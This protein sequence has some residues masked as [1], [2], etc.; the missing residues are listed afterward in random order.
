MA[1]YSNNTTVKTNA[2]VAAASGGF[3]ATLYTAP[4]NG[5]AIVNVGVGV[6]NGNGTSGVS[7]GGQVVAERIN[8][9][10]K[11]CTSLTGAPTLAANFNAGGSGVSAQVQTLSAVYVG[12]GQSVAAFGSAGIIYIWISG[13]EFV[14]TP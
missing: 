7:V 6:G 3:A 12:P 8:D 13:A 5:Y 9:A 11:G 4:S 1:T 14:N 10:T 2:A